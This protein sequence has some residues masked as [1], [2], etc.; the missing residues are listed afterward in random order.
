MFTMIFS[1]FA[2]LPLALQVA[3]KF[4]IIVVFVLALARLFAIVWD[5]LPFV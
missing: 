4:S 3:I 2:W 1:L 5:S